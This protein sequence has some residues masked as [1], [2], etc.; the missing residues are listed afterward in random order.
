MTLMARAVTFHNARIADL[1][2]RIA[3]LDGKE[4]Q[5]IVEQKRRDSANAR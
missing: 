5:H 3:A 4:P 1:E 2:K